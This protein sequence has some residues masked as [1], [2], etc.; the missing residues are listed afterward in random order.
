MDITVQVMAFPYVSAGDKN[1]V[2]AGF[3]TMDHED[4]VYPSGAH[5][6]DDPDRRRIL[7]PRDTCQ[8]RARIGTPVAKKRQDLR[9]K[10]LSHVF[11]SSF[12]TQA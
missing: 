6:S 10:W 8:I 11:L 2:K 4:G 1:A 9:F 3:E 12:I 5:G 7:N